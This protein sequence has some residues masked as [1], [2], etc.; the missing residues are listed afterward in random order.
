MIIYDIII[1]EQI[2]Q[3]NKRFLLPLLANHDITQA[4]NMNSPY[5]WYE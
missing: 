1:G 2:N 4:I 3:T 5:G